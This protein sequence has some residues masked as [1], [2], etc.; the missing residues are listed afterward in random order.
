MGGSGSGRQSGFSTAKCHE[1]HSVDLAWLRR[2]KMLTVGRISTLTWSVRGHKTGSIQIECVTRGIRLIYRNR[3]NGQD[4]RDATEL[5]PLIETTTRFGGSRQWFEC[6]TCRAR[7]RILYGGSYFRC[8]RCHRLKYD[9]QYEPP[10]ARAAT[11]ALKIR[12]RLGGK[13]GIDDTFPE[14]PK[15]M[16]RRTYDRLV[17]KQQRLQDAWARGITRRFNLGDRSE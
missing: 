6:L 13:G 17:A 4:W 10:F 5:V 1:Y 2:Q 15:G 9:T 16:H 3:E 14:K 8:R 11:R 7:C 12:E